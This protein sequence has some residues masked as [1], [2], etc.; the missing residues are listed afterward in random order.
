MPPCPPLSNSLTC[1]F[2][3]NQHIHLFQSLDNDLPSFGA[4]DFSITLS[5]FGSGSTQAFNTAV[6]YSATIAGLGL[7]NGVSYGDNNADPS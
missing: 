3:A 5:G 6:A 7:F 1:H 2:Y 4:E